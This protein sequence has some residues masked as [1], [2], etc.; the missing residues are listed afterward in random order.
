MASGAFFPQIHYHWKVAK[1]SPEI[2]VMSIR[3]EWLQEPLVWLYTLHQAKW[4]ALSYSNFWNQHMNV[5][6]ICYDSVR[7]IDFAMGLWWVT[8]VG[9]GWGQTWEQSSKKWM[10]A[11][12][13]LF[14][15]WSDVVFKCKMGSVVAH[16]D[17]LTPLM[18]HN[19]R[20]DWTITKKR[21]LTEYSL[22]TEN[23]LRTGRGT[24]WYYQIVTS[25]SWGRSR[26]TISKET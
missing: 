6:V 13:N 20:I 8:S 12:L 26:F 17:V 7:H 21:T 2:L 15:G 22:V 9:A 10:F 23:R 1:K 14:T 16:W 19:G 18:C 24:L 25:S 11:A 3:S 4:P 5:Q